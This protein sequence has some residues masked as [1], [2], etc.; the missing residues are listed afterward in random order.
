MSVKCGLIGLPNVGKSTLFNLLTKSNIPAENYPFCTIHPNIGISP[1]IDNRLLKIAKIANSKKIIYTY[2][3]FVDIAG[4]VKGASK[5]EGLGNQFLSHIKEIDAII[6]VVRCFENKNIIHVHNSINPIYDIEVINT[7]LALSDLNFCEKNILN[8]KKQEKKNNFK[9]TKKVFF[10]KKCIQYLE[11]FC[12]LRNMS[13]SI[14]EKNYAKEFK[15]LT[16]KPIMYV[17]NIDNSFKSNEIYKKIKDYLKKEKIISIPISLSNDKKP[18]DGNLL[19]NSLKNK[20]I[21][22]LDQKKNILSNIIDISLNLLKL[23][24]FFTVGPKESRAWIIKK[25]TT[26]IN[27]A[28]KIHS[29]LK[30]GFIRA[31]VMSYLDFISFKGEKNVK[32]AG[33]FRSEG[34]NY[35]VNDADILQIL[36]KV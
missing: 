17:A 11:K 22:Y 8:I 6:H 26:V 15:F 27:A 13:L 29:D 19:K 3:K 35:I 28:K 7:E 25:N 21:N 33:K 34:K 10:L 4:L 20:T 5:G 32:S 12:T 23:H 31:K 9:D 1:V 16:L 36:F 14:E 18:E 30:K 24:T 2:I